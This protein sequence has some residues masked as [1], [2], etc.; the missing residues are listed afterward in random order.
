M[1][2]RSGVYFHF[3]LN[4]KPCI[5][6]EFNDV[7]QRNFIIKEEDVNFHNDEIYSGTPFQ[8]HFL[9]P[10]TCCCFI[11]SALKSQFMKPLVTILLGEISLSLKKG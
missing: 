9:Y 2:L 5:R 10:D 1:Y 3:T 11:F 6:F 4:T 8:R 7:F